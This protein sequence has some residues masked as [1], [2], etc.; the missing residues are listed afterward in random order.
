MA[1]NI[2]LEEINRD[3]GLTEQ[4]CPV[5]CSVTYFCHVGYIFNLLANIVLFEKKYNNNITIVLNS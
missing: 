1:F 3:L 4:G 5:F 2:T